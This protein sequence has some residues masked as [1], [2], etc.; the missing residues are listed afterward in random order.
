MY[1]TP[2]IGIIG[3][4]T[5]G[6]AIARGFEKKARLHIYDPLYRADSGKGFRTPLQKFI[7]LAS[8][9]LSAC[10]LPKN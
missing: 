7:V 2:N 8:L 9:V 5:V 10:L 3:Y 6:K 1:I 4:G